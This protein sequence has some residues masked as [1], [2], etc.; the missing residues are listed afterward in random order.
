MKKKGHEIASEVDVEDEAAL[1]ENAKLAKESYLQCVGELHIAKRD[2]ID[3]NTK[4]HYLS[5]F[6]KRS[7][8]VV[9]LIADF[10]KCWSTKLDWALS[11]REILC[12][13]F[14]T[15]CHGAYARFVPRRKK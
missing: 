10:G 8:Y 12:C 4:R 11:F 6:E 7:A 1:V 2:N 15:R 5:S 13:L 14:E 3:F 9:G